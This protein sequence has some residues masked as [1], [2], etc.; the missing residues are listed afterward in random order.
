MTD[1]FNRK[2][3]ESGVRE[4]PAPPK[5]KPTQYAHDK[6]MKVL[7]FLLYLAAFAVVGLMAFSVGSRGTGY[8][9][10][11]AMVD[12][13]LHLAY[14]YG[15]FLGACVVLVPLFFISRLLRSKTM[16]FDRKL[17]MGFLACLSVA[18]LCVLRQLFWVKFLT[19]LPQGAF[20]TFYPAMWFVF[21]TWLAHTIYR[22]RYPLKG[23]YREISVTYSVG[24]SGMFLT[25]M[26]TLL[27]LCSGYD[28]YLGNTAMAWLSTGLL[29]LLAVV[30]SRHYHHRWMIRQA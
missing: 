18:A 22:T 21:L 28:F 20:L 27:G 15:A 2:P 13:Y 3:R 16:G 26:T 24:S 6:F 19:M 23:Y 14:I 5:E 4:H 25:W 11:N 30:V 29:V 10:S 9:L 7:A 12:P 1:I 17:L 8:S